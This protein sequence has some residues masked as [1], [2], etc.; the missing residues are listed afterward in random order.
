VV[1][2]RVIQNTLIALGPEGNEVWRHV[3]P[4]PLREDSYKTSYASSFSWLIADLLGDGTQEM[5]FR[6]DPV[7]VR[8]ERVFCLD[9]RG[10]TK[11]EFKAGRAIVDL[12]GKEFDPPYYPNNIVVARGANSGSATVVVSSNHNWSFP[13]QVALLDG[14]TGGL[15]SEYWHRGHLSQ[16]IATD[17]DGDGEPEVILGGVNDS[18]EYAVATL[19]VFDHRSI[20]G[21]STSRDGTPH[22][23][24]MPQGTEKA[25]VRFPKSPLSKDREFNHVSDIS[26]RDGHLMVDVLEGTGPTDPCII[27]ELNSRL[28]P[29]NVGLCDVA[30]ERYAAMRD[31]DRS[32]PSP[33]EL[34]ERL[35]RRVEIWRKR[36]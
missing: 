6:E 11:W 9:S 17:L 4:R 32:L 23:Q 5:L 29:V 10:R 1:G 21:S 33:Q 2:I 16:M 18:P 25:I 35:Q 31:K 15:L 36:D 26:L 34:T 22:F 24:G 12:K 3:F 27:Y 7:K 13:N 30:L 19:V 28:D 14:A 8:G 20:S